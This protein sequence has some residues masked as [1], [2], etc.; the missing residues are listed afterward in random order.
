MERYGSQNLPT[1]SYFAAG[2]QRCLGV[3]LVYD[4]RNS[5]TLGQLRRWIDMVK[6]VCDVTDDRLVFTLWGNEAGLGAGDVVD[7]DSLSGFVE[8]N[9]LRPSLVFSVNA[10]TGDGIQNSLERLVAALIRANNTRSDPMTPPATGTGSSIKLPEGDYD[11]R[12]W[13]CTCFT[14]IKS[15]LFGD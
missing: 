5:P 7:A 9:G 2:E 15:K 3:I 11:E 14:T 13:K 10:S 1:R 4:T 6:E 12:G 8:T